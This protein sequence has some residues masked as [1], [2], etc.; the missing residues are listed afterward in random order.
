MV[1]KA[2]VP[3]GNWDSPITVD[4]VATKSRQFSS[5]RVS[6]S[7][8]A[9]FQE[10]TTSGRTTIVEVIKYGVRDV[11]PSLYNASNRVYEYGS[12]AF[13]VLADNRI[14]FTN[15][16]DS[17]QILDPDSGKVRLVFR[18][19]YLRYASLSAGPGSWVLSIQEVHDQGCRVKNSVVAINVDTS[20]INLIAGGADF[21]YL[22]RFSR[23]GRRLS[24]LQW[25][26]PDLPFDSAQLHVA[27]WRD[28]F[29]SLESHLI[30]GKDHESVAEP[31]WGFDG[32]LYFAKEEGPYRQLYRLR[33]GS[34]Q[35]PTALELRGLEKVEFGEIGLYEGSRTIAP[36]TEE[37][38]VASAILNGSA[39]LV[40]IN[41]ETG[42]WSQLVEADTVCQVSFDAVT[43]FD[44]S[45]VLVIGSG[46]LSVPSI[47]ILNVHQ[48][49]L[50]RLVR[51]ATDEKFSPS[52]YAQP[53]G[54]SIQSVSQPCRDIHGFLWMP[55]NPKFAAATGE[56]PPL[57]ICAHGGPTSHMGCGVNL[58]TQYF[59]SRGY[60]FLG[61]NHAGST[62]YGRRYRSSL[63][64]NWGLLDVDDAA[65]FASYLVSHG[66]VKHDGVGITGFSAGG[67]STLQVLV[68]YSSLFAAGLCVSG[69]SDLNKFGRKTHKLE[70]NYTPKLVLPEGGVDEK[71][72]RRIYRD[73]SALYH[74]D[75]I[76]SPIVLLHGKA[77]PVVPVE[78]A[79]L[80]AK[81]LAK[82]GRQVGLVVVDGEGH[83][84][85]SPVSTRLWLKEE[86]SLWRRTLLSA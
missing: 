34:S 74:V 30:S 48:P 49:N 85:D 8:R 37:L 63:W 36:L 21:Y 53:E 32:S 76:T 65:E 39:R 50:N 9:F 86:E 31:T 26:D 58:R 13:D 17:I 29:R 79:K 40:L 52:L 41:V 14:V 46:T 75:N 64:G 23:D 77:D 6:P 68:R 33:P 1:I 81:A 28:G 54:I 73:R 44:E 84:M 3:Y 67:Y 35:V 70:A 5:P 4:S 43:R 82:R 51:E 38:L 22:P 78:Q 20:H 71:R 2:I 19:A 27:D 61:L 80:M 72:K 69:I 45:S 11:L 18:S 47:R 66:R 16:D 56:R 15:S 59:T 12:S 55:R 83:M 10:K 62:G 25:D 42:S 24:W 57:I 7:G 60:A